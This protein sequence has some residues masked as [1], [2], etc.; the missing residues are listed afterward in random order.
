MAI[1]AAR[2]LALVT[3]A[4]RGIGAE[5]ARQLAEAGYAVVVTARDGAAAQAH[6]DALVAEGHDATAIALDIGDPDSVAALV[7][8]LGFRALTVLVNNAAAFADWTETATTADLEQARAVMDTNLFGAWRVVQALLP[9]LARAGS[10]RIVNVGSGSG[11][12]GDPQFGLPTNPAS[13]SYAVSKAALHALT[14][15]LAT[16]LR[17]SGVLVNAVDPGLTATAP[18]MEAMG[19]R[20]VPDGA[21]SVVAAALL[22]D[23]GPTGTFTRDGEPLPW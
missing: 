14:V 3:G 15:K 23:D 2:P 12:H 21:R 6:A 13:A 4:A 1:D 11:S 9:A 16:E 19:A 8:A 17:P 7:D 18:G 20:P 10:S 5:V 22:P